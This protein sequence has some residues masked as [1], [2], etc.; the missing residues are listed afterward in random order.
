MKTETDGFL[1]WE[2]VSVDVGPSAEASNGRAHPIHISPINALPPA[3]TT[4]GENILYV[5]DR[6]QCEI[7]GIVLVNGMHFGN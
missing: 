1:T 2:L 7:Y 3:Q 5:M 4:N 6:K